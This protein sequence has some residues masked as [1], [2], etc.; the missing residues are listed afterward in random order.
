[1]AMRE[2]AEDNLRD[3]F[4]NR[5]FIIVASVLFLLTVLLL[6]I[7]PGSPLHAISG[8]VSAVLRPFER[9]FSGMTGQV[10]GYLAAWRD[11][12][13]LRSENDELTRENAVLRSEIDQLAEAGR[14]YQELKDAFALKDRFANYRIL[15]AYKLTDSLDTWFDVF[16]IDLGTSDGIRTSDGSREDGISYPVVDAASRLIGRI[17]TADLMSS[18]VVTLI[19]E[20]FA[21][22]GRVEKETGAMVRVRGDV[23]LKPRKLCLVDLVTPA[24]ANLAVG[25]EIRTSGNGGLFPAGIPIGRIVELRAGKNPDQQQAVLKPYADLDRLE[26]VF[27][28]VAEPEP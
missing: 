5:V 27:V 2:S 20:G 15:G 14:R 7:P 4:R 28:M 13:A 18:K 26:I 12:A 3:F 16:R 9:L 6:S 24:D 19:H 8:P 23:E 1:M 21:V 22:S 11:S 10:R 25:D 17:H